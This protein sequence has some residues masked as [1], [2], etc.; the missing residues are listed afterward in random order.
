[1]I[2]FMII[3]IT[4]ALLFVLALKYIITSDSG[5]YQKSSFQKIAHKL[6][7]GVVLERSNGQRARGSIQSHGV[8]LFIENRTEGQIV[9]LH[10]SLPTHLEYG[11]EI[12][13]ESTLSSLSKK[14]GMHDVQ[15]HHSAFDEQ[16]LIKGKN[17]LG[18]I[19]LLDN[20]S[21]QLLMGLRKHFPELSSCHIHGSDLFINLKGP[22][23][24]HAYLQRLLQYSIKLSKHLRR[25]TPLETMLTENIV[26]DPEL[27]VRK[28]NLRLLL[29]NFEHTAEL[30]TLLQQIMSNRR[31][32]IELRFEAAATLGEEGFPY[33]H[34]FMNEAPG[35][36]AEK[37]IRA[38]ARTGKPEVLPIIR[39]G[40]ATYK[41]LFCMTAEIL[42]EFRDR[43]SVPLLIA[44]R[45]NLDQQK[46]LLALA[47]VLGKIGDGR[48]QDCLI[49][50]L[51][52]N[53][54]EVRTAAII[55]LGKTGS[56]NAVEPLWK[57]AQA[58]KVPALKS[59][60]QESITTIQARHGPGEKG[61]L[62]MP[63]PHPTTGSLSL[64]DDHTT[65]AVSL[66]ENLGKNED[67]DGK[68]K[69]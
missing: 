43:E 30:S 10:L 6:K 24:N 11:L 2:P 16:F 31:E 48:A 28:Q 39:D 57:I 35:T 7:L 1:M 40:L 19:G 29:Q 13:L 63:H 56:V 54:Q 61:W 3:V 34:A 12:S 68:K 26:S 25:S 9:R 32:N 38:L 64:G 14:M 49:S 51:N 55:A 4:S 67:P 41:F 44:A 5:P 66:D 59:A 33:L 42:G 18:I 8:D 47:Q 20:Q 58:S 21:R 60:A 45:Q 27:E 23:F 17:E 65:G 36:L 69:E 15:L 62:S 50:L 22:H 37:V 53:D 46:Q 52:E